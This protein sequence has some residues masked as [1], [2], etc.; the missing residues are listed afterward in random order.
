MNRVYKKAYF[1]LY[2]FDNEYIIHNTRKEFQEGH[3]HIKNYK[4][5]VFII[6]L[7]LHKS[8]PHHLYPYLLESLRRI[9]DDKEYATKIESLLEIKNNKSKQYYFN[10]NKGV[11]KKRRS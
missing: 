9:T 11:R 6:D 8:I 1:N 10:S 7:A 5:A 4:T 3:T 2:Q